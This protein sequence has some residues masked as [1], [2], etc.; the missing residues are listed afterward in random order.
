LH[1]LGLEGFSGGDIGHLGGGKCCPGGGGAEE[2]AGDGC[3]G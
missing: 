1:G 3:F 2:E